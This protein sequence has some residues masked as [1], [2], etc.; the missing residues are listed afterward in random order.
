MVCLAEI[1]ALTADRGPQHQR[2]LPYRFRYKQNLFAAEFT[3]TEY[4]TQNMGGC[5]VPLCSG[6]GGHKFPLSDPDRA[7]KWLQAIKRKDFQPTKNSLVCRAHFKPND[8]FRAD[9]T[10]AGK[11]R[12]LTYFKT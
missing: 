10:Q 1:V 4:W 11:F 7:K 8:Y 6:K 2:V 5:C 9:V 3:L 12:F